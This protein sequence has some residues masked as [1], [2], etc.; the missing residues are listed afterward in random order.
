[1]FIAELKV[2]RIMLNK[3][4]LQRKI[5]TFMLVFLYLE[6]LACLCSVVPLFFTAFTKRN[7]LFQHQ[8]CITEANRGGSRG[9]GRD[10]LARC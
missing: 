3:I 4:Y 5:F 8:R 1:M 9:C 10:R 7:Q 6:V 2:R